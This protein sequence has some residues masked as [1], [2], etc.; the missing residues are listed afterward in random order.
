M[1]RDP[2]PPSG[3]P[4]QRHLWKVQKGDS[5]AEAVLRTLPF[6]DEVRV[7]VRGELLT[8]AEFHDDAV[9][10]ETFSRDVRQSFLKN[11]W[12]ES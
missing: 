2:L 9:K 7:Y 11:G 4:S 12:R 6:G 10:L 5:T 1:T 3:V 8:S